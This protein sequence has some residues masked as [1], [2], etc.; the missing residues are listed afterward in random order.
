MLILAVN[1][2]DRVTANGRDITDLYKK[3][4]ERVW[5]FVHTLFD[6]GA[7]EVVLLCQDEIAM[8][9]GFD[10]GVSNIYRYRRND[11][12]DLVLVNN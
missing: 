11:E 12:G 8:R 4:L 5:S 7:P 6:Q 1:E 3:G 9:Y 10:V 2:Y